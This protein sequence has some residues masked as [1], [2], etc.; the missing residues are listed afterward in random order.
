LLQIYPELSK[1]KLAFTAKYENMTLTN[2]MVI[3]WNGSYRFVAKNEKG[4]TVNFD[5]P[6]P[7]GGEESAL[8]PME[9]VLASLA[10]CS[11]IH[12]ISLL[13]EHGQDVSGYHVEIQA[14][15]MKEPP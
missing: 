13:N 9:N 5:A 6:K 12:L 10:A 4:I 7:F 1:V 14:E 8:S 11:S 3:D 2:K 15:R